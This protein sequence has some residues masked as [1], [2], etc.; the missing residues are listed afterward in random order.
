MEDGLRIMNGS[1][2]IPSSQPEID[3]VHVPIQRLKGVV[4]IVPEMHM[5]LQH[6]HLILHLR[7]PF[8][9]QEELVG[10]RRT[11]QV[12]MLKGMETHKAL[13]PPV[14]SVVIMTAAVEVSILM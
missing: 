5:N 9:I 7:L 3:I 1:V 14:Q 10:V 6:V 11:H 2:Q 13:A 4:R 8:V 12:Q